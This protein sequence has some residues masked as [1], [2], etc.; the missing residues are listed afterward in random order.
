MGP[1][2][3]SLALGGVLCI[4]AQVTWRTQLLVFEVAD[5]ALKVGALCG[6]VALLVAFSL[7]HQVPVRIRA[8]TLPEER[9]VSVLMCS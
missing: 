4:P 1:P 6:L 3:R 9:A 2:G 5:P 8:Y 7:R